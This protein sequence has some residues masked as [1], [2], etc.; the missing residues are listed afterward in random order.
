[1]EKIMHNVYI[2]PKVETKEDLRK[3]I[4]IEYSH[5][6]YFNYMNKEDAYR[7]AISYVEHKYADVVQIL[8]E[9]G[10]Y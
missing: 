8:K 4:E 2:V 10:K 9:Q 6:V 5:L 1:M 7:E 3:K